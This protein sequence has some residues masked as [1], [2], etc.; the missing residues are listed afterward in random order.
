MCFGV[1][2][3][4]KHTLSASDIMSNKPVNPDPR[5]RDLIIKVDQKQLS[6]LDHDPRKMGIA[7]IGFPF[8]EGTLRNGGR[9]GSHRGPSVFRQHLYKIGCVPNAEWGH[10]VAQNVVIYDCGDIDSSLNYDAAHLALSDIVETA[11]RRRL[12]PFV[13][14]GSNDESFFNFQG[15][16]KFLDGGNRLHDNF[17]VINIDAHFDVRPQKNGM[18]H[19]GSPFRMMLDCDLYQRNKGRFT[20]FAV[21]GHQCSAV[22]YEYIMSK[23]N[24]KV[25]WLSKDLRRRERHHGLSVGQQFRECL[26]RMSGKEDRALFV[27]FDVDSIRQ[28]DCPGVSCPSPIGLTAEEAGDICFKSGLNRNVILMDLSEF[29]PEAEEYNTG[30]LLSWMFYQFVLGVSARNCTKLRSRL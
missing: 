6:V 24:T 3:T 15:M 18:E 29:C 10:D 14:G 27:S 8:D 4:F 22:Q 5:L 17:G 1:F 21:Q 7:L 25:L 20:E 2:C 13:V 26:D 23:P 30:K 28:S 12:I 19:S 11:L 16:A 9:G